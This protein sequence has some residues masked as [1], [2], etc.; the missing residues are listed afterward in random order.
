MIKKK[1]TTARKNRKSW[2]V[3]NPNAGGI[4][5]A[6][7]I[8]YAAIG[9][10]DPDTDVR[11][12]GATTNE[13]KK[14]AEWF[15][16]NGVNT[17]AL[18]ATGVYWIPPIQILESYGIEVLL[19]HPGHVR[20]LK[21]K[22]TDVKDSQW[23]QKL[24]TFGLLEGAFRPSP[25]A[26]VLRSYMRRRDTLVKMST[27]HILHMQKALDQMN[28]RVH[29]A[30]TD[31]SGKTGLKIIKAILGGQRDP[32][33]L[34]KLRHGT[35]KLSA[36]EMAENLNGDFREEHLFSLRQSL[37]QYEFTQEQILECDDTVSKFLLQ[38][39]PKELKKLTPAMIKKL[40]RKSDKSRNTF[41][42]DGK[43]MA[44]YLVGVDLTTIPGFRSGSV[45]KILSE[46]GWT[47]KEF[48]TPHHL[49]SWLG[50]CPGSDTSG[51][52][53]KSGK[54]RRSSSRAAEAFRMAAQSIHRSQDPLA[55]FYRRMKARM[56]P[57][58]AITATAHKMVRI[59]YKMVT[60]KVEYDPTL[61]ARDAKKEKEMKIRRL[62][63]IASSLGWGL[64]DEDGV[65]HDGVV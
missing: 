61:I 24:H 50:L 34:G 19:V 52:K 44:E 30:V 48:P 37:A 57:A 49:A 22:K 62:K 12:F 14:M 38:Y 63:K 31:I 20:I 56:G 8:H 21:G 42:F 9:H 28:V 1:K 64:V 33:S 58:Q 60:D 29:R 15:R 17:I 35:C 54:T 18:E 41:N 3:V 65:I 4:D 40:N 26:G 39:R 45:L 7:E 13:L 59:F 2:K 16:E 36:E 53:S 23:L 47:L 5:L 25:D 11:S 55:D 27:K 43:T 10:E 46:T 32:L 6:S 51:G